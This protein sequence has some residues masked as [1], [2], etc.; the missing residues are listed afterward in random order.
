M[1]ALDKQEKGDSENL[2]NL[3]EVQLLAWWTQT[4]KAVNHTALPH[5]KRATLA[6]MPH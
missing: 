5:P 3:P 1:I 6:L 2:K 4:Q